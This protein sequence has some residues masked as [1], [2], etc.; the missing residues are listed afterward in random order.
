VTND[1]WRPEG[2]NEHHPAVS[3]FSQTGETPARGARLF[4]D[5]GVKSVSYV[6]WFK[7]D[8]TLIAR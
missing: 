1:A 6:S 4:E 5:G 3:S 8:L 2:E 7:T